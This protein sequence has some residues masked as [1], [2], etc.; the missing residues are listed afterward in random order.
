[1]SHYF[2]IAL[3]C[4]SKNH[5]DN[6]LEVY[7]P[8]PTLN[9]DS[10][11]IEVIR[12][13]I[14]Y[15][16]GNAAIE[17]TYRQIQHLAREWRDAGYEHEASYAV[18]FQESQRP[19]VI[20]VL[21]T[22]AEPASTPEA[23]LKLHLLS[24]RLVKPNAITLAGIAPLLPTIAWTSEGAVD[25]DELGERQMLAQLEGRTL[26]VRSVDS[27]PQMAD[28]IVPSGVHIADTARVRL[29]AYLGE[30]TTVMPTG[31]IDFNA[32]AQGPGIIEGRLAAGVFVDQGTNISDDP[33]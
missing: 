12:E 15:L 16:G 23:Y 24:H 6:W 5:D 9:P 29:G 31:F 28:Y 3:G 17:L 8:D 4:G 27:F 26:S 22:D 33:S 10:R 1:M 18:A 32:G 30:G 13:E 21:E 19:V 25:P 20:T 14:G 2:A 11:L 7:Y